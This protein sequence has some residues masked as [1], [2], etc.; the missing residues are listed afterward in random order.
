MGTRNHPH[1]NNIISLLGLNRIL[2]F[3]TMVCVGVTDRNAS[4]SGAIPSM[5]HPTTAIQMTLI[6]KRLIVK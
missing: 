6:T 4:C 3:A 1:L 2:L 5:R